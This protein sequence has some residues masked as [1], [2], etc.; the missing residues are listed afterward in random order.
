MAIRAIT[1]RVFILKFFLEK[2][3]NASS[4][5]NRDSLAKRGVSALL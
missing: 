5:L 4:L 2:V 1:N 3:V